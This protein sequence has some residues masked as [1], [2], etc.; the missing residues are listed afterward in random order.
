MVATTRAVNMAQKATLMSWSSKSIVGDFEVSGR[1]FK[2]QVWHKV[3]DGRNLVRTIG[4]DAA[5]GRNVHEVGDTGH[6]AIEA[7]VVSKNK[8]GAENE[9]TLDSGGNPWE[10]GRDVLIAVVKTG[11][12]ELF[13]GGLKHINISGGLSI[14]VEASVVF[15]YFFNGLI[16]LITN[17]RDGL[18][19]NGVDGD[20]GARKVRYASGHVD[21][22]TSIGERPEVGVVVG[23][24]AAQ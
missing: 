3:G 17:G 5:L 23:L 20:L 16:T 21:D 9:V 13:E 6:R 24:V 10:R 1:R 8:V 2:F 19:V 7:E 12:G 15:L 14:N 11:L 18:I 22:D 4:I